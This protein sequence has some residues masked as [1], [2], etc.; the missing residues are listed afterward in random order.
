MAS[1]SSG[2]G[3]QLVAIAILGVASLALFILTI[4]FLSKYQA[5][6]RNLK[7]A[8]ADTNE[9]IRSDERR[10]DNVTQ[11]TTK[12]KQGNK[13]VFGYLNESLREAMT[14]TTGAHTD[15]VAELAK[16]M[17]DA[18]VT[19]T[20]L[21]AALN[22]RKNEIAAMD[23][24]VKQADAA[25]ATA[26]AD[27]ENEVNRTKALTESHNRTIQAMNA[28]IDKYKAEVEAFRQSVG[29]TQ[30][31]MDSEVTKAREAM[32]SSQSNLSEQIRTLQNDNLRLK[33]QI[34][35]MNAS[36]SGSQLR[37]KAEQTHVDGEII[38]INQAA[39]TITISRGRADKVILGMSFAV[40]PDATAIR[41]DAATGE[42]IRP[43]ATIEVINVGD[44]TS[45]ARITSE[46]KGN[47]VVRGDVIANALYDPTKVYTV[48]VYGNFDSNGDGIATPQEAND[49]K[50]LVTGW[51]GKVVDDLTGNVDFLILGERPSL[52]APPGVNDT[53]EVV[54]NYMRLSEIAQRYDR[55]FEQASSTSTPVLNQNRFYT[56]IGRRAGSR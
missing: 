26:I 31:F 52:P 55:L 49:I 48:V 43:K 3:G 19:G 42:Y 27:L 36:A 23:T 41:P 40:F 21:L 56:L 9:I 1:R 34:S 2:G 22:D 32:A 46:V 45:T 50:A 33:D 51:G 30:A 7:Q 4:V 35:K 17:D 53:P 20:N 14:R 47:P 38:S 29:E 37:P 8:M 6:D 28:D 24:K 5:A 44:V 39:N 16:K 15:T 54:Q 25:R 10:G 11:I 13:S 12:A 18:G